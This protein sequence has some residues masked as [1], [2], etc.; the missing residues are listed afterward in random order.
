MILAAKAGKQLVLVTTDGEIS[1]GAN[2]G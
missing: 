1:S 2:V